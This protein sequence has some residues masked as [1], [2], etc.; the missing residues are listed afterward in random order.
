MMED[1]EYEKRKAEID[2]C[3]DLAIRIHGSL[4]AAE[5]WLETKTDTFWNMSPYECLGQGKGEDVIL[6]LKQKLGLA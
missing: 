5:H 3:R 6:L 4:E 2:E 1:L